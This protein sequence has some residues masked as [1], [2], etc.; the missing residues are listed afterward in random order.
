MDTVSL[1]GVVDLIQRKPGE[2]SGGQQQRTALARALAVR[3]KFLLLDEPFSS[4]D[5]TTK[6]ELL[7]D[8]RSLAAEHQI[9]LLLVTHD[10]VDVMT[11]CSSLLVME[12]GLLKEFGPIAE[13]MKIRPMSGF[14]DAF[15]RRSGVQCDA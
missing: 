1:C 15:M 5:L 11:L 12:A 8:I 4:L 7:T 14:L 10:P 13:L 9:T 6:S 2:L 3:P